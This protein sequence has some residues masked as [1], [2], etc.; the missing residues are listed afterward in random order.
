M[1]KKFELKTEEHNFTNRN[2]EILLETKVNQKYMLIMTTVSLLI[3]D[4][5]KDSF[6]DIIRMNNIFHFWII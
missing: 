1:E 5:N 4:I 6:I 3:F 2:I